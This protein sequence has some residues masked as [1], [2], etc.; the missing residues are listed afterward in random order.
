MS[1]ET[2]HVVLVA[3]AAD[4]DSADGHWRF[5]L[6]SSQ[7]QTLLD[8]EDSEPGVQGE[9]LELLAVVRGLEAIDHPSRV[10]V[11]TGSHYV[12]RMLTL[13]LDD[14]RENG[15][16]WEH[17]GQWVPIKH[18]DLWQ[19]VDRALLFHKVECRR[20][21]FDAGHSVVRR[22]RTT[23]IFQRAREIV[24]DGARRYRESAG[25]RPALA[26]S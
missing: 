12:N 10:T 9:R 8:A 13:G 24:S 5:V 26:A 25:M 11:V 16:C 2:P 6:R 21:R 20:W 22:P 14:W 17:Y 19:R 23:G 15:W 18:A 7:G 1:R 4:A 3:E